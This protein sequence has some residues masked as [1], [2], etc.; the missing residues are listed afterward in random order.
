MRAR[1]VL[2]AACLLAGCATAPVA[3]PPPSPPVDIRAQVMVLGVYHFR[4]SGRD[5][6]ERGVDDHLAPQRQAE[7]AEVLNRLERF[8]PTKIVVELDPSDESDFN[9]RYARYRAGAEA[10]TA[11]ERDQLGMGLAGRLGLD[12]LHAAD[13]PNNM[14]F[15]EM[16]AAAEAAGQHHLVERFHA[17]MATIQAH[18][19]ETRDLSVR[20]Q[21]I[22]MN[23]PEVVGWND[24]YMTM[25]QMGT[26]DNPIGAQDMVE[27]WGRNMYIFA[28]IARVAEP[29][30]RILVIYG[31]GHKF[32]LDQYFRQA[33][34]FE[35]IDPLTYLR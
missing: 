19:A 25:A 15:A 29:G 6:V 12:R 4:A 14:R 26:R 28:D 9:A 17:D 2:A 23:S 21:L 7:I 11:N 13:A 3:T 16:L 24:Y 34:E 8:R 20:A 32:L 18:A 27:W 22:E 30:D 33:Q 10:L 5:Y 35:L 1:N 31:A